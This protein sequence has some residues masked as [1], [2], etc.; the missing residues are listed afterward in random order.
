MQVLSL[1]HVVI[2]VRD[3]QRSVPFFTDALGLRLV[4]RTE[5]RGS[6][7]AFFSISG[8]HHD[9]ALLE[10]G[11]EAPSAPDA[12]PGLA[13]L[14]LK[15]GNSLDELRA[16]RTWLQGKGIEIERT[17]DHRVAQ[18]LYIA[19]PDR[20]RIELY[21]DADSRIWRED[22]GSVAHSEPLAL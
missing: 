9:L 3:L 16:A 2:K 14:A 1:G 12:A 11:K 17:V 8:N 4:A 22:P 18:S 5:I 15:I 19:D 7:M 13:H 21:V 20:N 10:T 6:P